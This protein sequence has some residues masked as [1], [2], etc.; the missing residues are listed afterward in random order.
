MPTYGFSAFLKILSLN[1][2]PQR[3]EIRQRYDPRP[4]GGYDFHRSLRR[5]AKRYL[6][7]G[8]DYRDVFADTN[9][10]TK[11]AE[12]VS[13]QEGLARLERWRNIY[14]GA[15]Y[16]I[17]PR[18]FESPNGVFKVHYTPD[19]GIRIDGKLT[20][21]HLWNTSKPPLVNRMVYTA[22]AIFPT[23]YRGEA[24]AIEDLGVLS[25]KDGRLYRLSDVEDHS[26]IAERLVK[27][28]ELQMTDIKIE[29]E[30]RGRIPPSQD[31][32]IPRPV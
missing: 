27:V 21:I 19:L 18:T 32:D 8:D 26:L 13:A 23:L 25:L 4:S 24:P 1:D 16:V 9:A 10:I 5:L 30:N 14:P 15:T 28:L 22:M 29:E 7:D 6:I 3:R 11:D 2:R 12:K 17:P 20:A 31:S